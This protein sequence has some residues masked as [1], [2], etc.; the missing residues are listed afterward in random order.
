[1]RPLKLT[2]QLL[3]VW[4]VSWL[5]GVA[6]IPRPS[7]RFD[8]SQYN[9]EDIITRDVGIIGGG[10]AGTYAAIRLRQLNQS[11]VVVEQNDHLGGHVNT[12]TDPTTGTA[13]DYGV[14]YYEDLPLVHNY[15]NH[16]RIPL[17]RVSVLGQGVTQR[18]IDLRT[19]TPVGAAEGN[20]IL[21]LVGYAAQLL[22]YPTLNSGFN[23]P[24]PVPEDLLLPF[25]EFV[26]KYKLEGA[27]DT[28]ALFNQGVGDLLQQLTLYMMKY[29]SLDVLQGAL[30]G[31]LQ[32]ASHNNS[33]LY[34]AA[35]RELSNDTLLSSTIVG[36]HRDE[37]EEG[38][39]YALARTPSGQKLIR[40]RKLI[41]AIPPKLENLQSIDL[42]STE[43]GLFAQF[44]NTCYYNALARIPGFPPDIGVVNRANDTPYQL[45]PQPAVYVLNPTRSNLTAILYGSVDHMSEAEVKGNM[46]Q[47]V[48]QLR[49]AGLPV[50]APEFVGYAD[51][52]PFLLTVPANA[53]RNGFYRNLSALQGHR[54]TYYM[55]AAFNTHD[56]AQIWQ[57]IEELLRRHFPPPDVDGRAGGI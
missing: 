20:M 41:V 36:T 22:K 15:F 51:H 1:M 29:F 56:S 9:T 47:G 46:T 16:F 37:D 55:S 6:A 11:V 26:R 53:I 39:V 27:V 38:G 13:V 12:Y 32:P 14:L 23:L 31:F 25:G 8:P 19:G 52:S 42:D 4:T 49:N 3:A 30:D 48:L 18:R 44:N 5:D 34:G 45:P 43:R 24:E 33:E 10:S 50:Q 21:G 54:N 40:V 35:Q 28:I 7:S 2:A 57:F 17:V